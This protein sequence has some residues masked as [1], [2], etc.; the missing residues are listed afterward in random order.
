MKCI[1]CKKRY[2]CEIKKTILND[3]GTDG[4]F[5]NPL[6]EIKCDKFVKL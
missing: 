2:N 5:N 1:D 4:E 6:L 3:R